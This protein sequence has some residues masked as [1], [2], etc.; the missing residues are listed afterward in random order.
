MS[1]LT[2]IVPNDPQASG[3]AAKGG[4]GGAGEGG[5]HFERDYRELI[6][7]LRDSCSGLLLDIFPPEIHSPYPVSACVCVSVCVSVWCSDE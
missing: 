3:G 1:S 5:G 7:L 6:G 2:Q 4:S